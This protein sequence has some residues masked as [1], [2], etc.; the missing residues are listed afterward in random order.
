MNS[1]QSSRIK[2][3]VTGAYGYS[4]RYITHRLLDL[5]H[6]VMTLTNSPNRWNPFGDRV[7]ASSF[8]FERKGVSPGYGRIWNKGVSPGYEG[9]SPHL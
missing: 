6:E 9:V 2:V 8:H 3:A 4:G 5:G 1:Q 7:K